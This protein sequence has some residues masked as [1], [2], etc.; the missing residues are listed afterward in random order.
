MIQKLLSSPRVEFLCEF[1]TTLVTTVGLEL[2]Q[3]RV[4]IQI[5]D[6]RLVGDEIV[7]DPHKRCSR[8]SSPYRWRSFGCQHFVVSSAPNLTASLS[9]PHRLAI[10]CLLTAS[11]FRRHACLVLSFHTTHTPRALTEVDEDEGEV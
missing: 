6:A 3:R 10:R 2:Y 9:P 4:W 7:A 11:L 1:G 8:T 5:V